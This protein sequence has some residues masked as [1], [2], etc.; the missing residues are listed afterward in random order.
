M[1][2]ITP[3]ATNTH[4]KCGVENCSHH[5]PTDYCSLEQIEVGATCS[6]EV[7]DCESTE[8][9]SFELDGNG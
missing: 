6:G 3:N 8:C 9:A 4:I 1:N 5:A 7:T 2:Q